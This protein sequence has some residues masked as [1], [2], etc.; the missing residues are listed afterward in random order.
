MESGTF[1]PNHLLV[2]SLHLPWEHGQ[3]D[4]FQ[5]EWFRK[6]A[7]R[8]VLTYIMTDVLLT[9]NTCIM[10]MLRKLAVPPSAPYSPV[11]TDADLPASPVALRAARRFLQVAETAMSKYPSPHIMCVIFGT[12]QGYV[13]CACVASTVMRG[14]GD[15][16]VEDVE[17]LEGVTAAAAGI[18]REEAGF[19]PLVVALR[20]ICVGLRK[21]LGARGRAFENV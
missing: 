3:A 10:F 12:Y 7:G 15:G 13:A 11:S 6:V 20:E 2:T 8:D 17:L 1:N 4:R 16:G 18:S 14:E 5:H 19:E 9:G 21:R